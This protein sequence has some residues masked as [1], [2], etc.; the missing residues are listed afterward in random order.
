MVKPYTDMYFLMLL[1]YSRMVSSQNREVIPLNN[2]GI[3]RSVLFDAVLEFQTQGE[4]IDHSLILFDMDF[5]QPFAECSDEDIDPST[6]SSVLVEGFNFFETGGSFL[7]DLKDRSMFPVLKNGDKIVFGLV[8]PDND[9][10]ENYGAFLTII[11]P[12]EPILTVIPW[13]LPEELQPRFANKFQIT[14]GEIITF[15]VLNAHNLLQLG[16]E[17]AYDKCL[18][19]NLGPEGL[20]VDNR[21]QAVNVTF[22]DIN[23][24]QYF[25]CN[26]TA[27]ERYNCPEGSNDCDCLRQKF[28][29]E[30][31]ARGEPFDLTFGEPTTKGE[32]ILDEV[33]TIDP[34]QPVRFNF[35][36]VGLSVRQFHSQNAFDNCQFDTVLG[37]EPKVFQ[38]LI[39]H[40]SASTESSYLY[41]DYLQGASEKF[42]KLYFG[43]D[44]EVDCN[45]QLVSGCECGLKQAINVRLI[46]ENENELVSGNNME[47]LILIGS[48]SLISLSIIIALCSLLRSRRERKRLRSEVF[49]TPSMIYERTQMNNASVLDSLPS[50]EIEF[51]PQPTEEADST[52]KPLRMK[53]LPAFNASADTFVPDLQYLKTTPRKNAK[54][55]HVIPEYSKEKNRTMFTLSPPIPPKTPKAKRSTQKSLQSEKPV[56]ASPKPEARR[57]GFSRKPSAEAT[58]SYAT[59]KQ[60]RSTQE[61]YLRESPADKSFPPPASPRKSKKNPKEEKYSLSPSYQDSYFGF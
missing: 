51:H 7:V 17:E 18:V 22:G 25:T 33:P 27:P 42:T 46:E 52:T 8:S 14:Q 45:G 58:V 6:Y 50:S 57:R 59:S 53:T 24:V 5:I 12:P 13:N 3:G 10:E 44:T 19:D 15:D 56:H 32:T 23:E 36:T 1:S 43:I 2:L 31:V 60:T 34:N 26:K 55:Q 35:E 61:H 37:Q 4:L 28:R 40:T 11:A 38:A 30:V 47:F 41:R 48:L 39:L 9:C 29:I 49:E 20:I 16:S 54:L 21:T